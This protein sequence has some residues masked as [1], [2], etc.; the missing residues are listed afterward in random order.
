MSTQDGQTTQKRRWRMSR[1]G[2]L[3]GLGA[4]GV[5]VAVGLRFGVPALRLT[6]AQS[7]ERSGAPGGVNAP[8]QAWFE[9]L[10][11][12]RV[13]LFIPKIEMGQGI[14]TSLAQ[15]G[16]EE[17]EVA[18][19]Q[20]IVKQ[21]DTARGLE[22]NFGTGASNSISTLFTPLREA[23]AT[24]REML[25]AEAARQLGVDAAGL[26]VA[27]GVF[28]VRDNPEQA[29]SYGEIVQ[30]ADPSSWEV[31]EEA[32][33]LKPVGEFKLIGT[34]VPRVDFYDKL[35]GTA[36]YGYDARVDGMLYGAVARP[37][38][39]EGKLISADEGSA[40]ESAG[41]V[42][43]VIDGEFVGVV[44]KSRLQAAGGLNGLNLTW[45]DGRA[46]QQEE[47]DAMVT[48]GEGTGTVIQKEGDAAGMLKGEGIILAEYRSP[49]AAHAHLEPQAALVDV[50]PDK[51]TAWVSTQS[52]FLVRG[53]IAEAL[54]RDESEVVV[55]PTYL[56][57]GFGRR[58]KVRVAIEA[59]R[60]SA[61]VGRPVHVG[62]NR[63]DEFRN[64]YF[65]PPTHNVLRARV[66]GQRIVALEH[67]QASSDVAFST[68]PGIAATVLGADFGAYRGAMI[69]YGIP[70]RR[71]VAW[72][73]TLPVE[74]GWWRGLG[75]LANTFAV[76]S[77][78]DEVAAA[79][80]MDPLQL[81]LA[82][83]PTGEMGER[84]RRA[85]ETVAE[86][87]NWG[88]SL[89]DGRAR[90]IAIA[91]D[92]K[93]V[94]AHV[95][96]VS[97]EGGQIRVHRIDVA[98]DP[99]LVINPDGAKAQAQ[100]AIMMAMGSTL[101]EEITIQDGRVTAANFDSYPLLTMKEAPHIEV[102]L[103]QSGE[104]P[105]GLGEPP[106][107]PAAAAVANAVYALTGQRLRRMPLRLG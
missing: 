11:D 98:L 93:T 48:I 61:A 87:A 21:A 100:G 55:I 39:I 79:V 94:V 29:I 106:M 30:A 33:A 1:R 35:T 80:G 86:Q 20:V 13:T 4:A 9:I 7:L 8:P 102:T 64:G 66:D 67:Q 69:A 34:S 51:V 70:N 57:G 82:H 68:L 104:E 107:G 37:Q 52:P 31:P 2:F 25:R 71:T 101:M 47:I 76:E 75:L 91:N 42:D 6:I 97:V 63:T 73:N 10:P 27:N 43:V 56:G 83:L 92:V 36:V 95:A 32:P 96:E 58:L 62:W 89:P 90:G 45:D 5:G 53:D 84:Y 14:H 38:T 88:G 24:M 17:L 41:V 22:D 3:I 18:W 105:F 16:A 77:F 60:L 74:T 50:Q 26:I 46:W 19:D 28:Q 15:I 85:L 23:A 12:N 49:L 81:R 78:M 72:Y 40:R 65:R 44:A 54:G 103:L 59:A 99:G